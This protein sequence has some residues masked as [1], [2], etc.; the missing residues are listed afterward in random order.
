MGPVR[1]PQYLLAC[2]LSAGVF[3]CDSGDLLIPPTPARI[4][5][6]QG[7]GQL[8]SPGAPLPV[9][10]MVKVLDEQGEA[11][12]GVP[13]AFELADPSLGGSV[14][15]DTAVTDSR[16]LAV[17]RWTL[18]SPG[19]QAVSAEGVGASLNV[20]FIAT[21]EGESTGSGTPSGTRSTISVDPSTIDA[22]TGTATITVIV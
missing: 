21:G 2:L 9:M 15:P 10:L 13:V 7:N 20:H 1:F 14:A 6:V 18:G 22:G 16:G 17:A 11:I 5:M 3:A 19:P 8:G 12:A 4:E